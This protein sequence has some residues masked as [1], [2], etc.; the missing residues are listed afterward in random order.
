VVSA[1]TAAFE[2]YDHTTA[3]ATTEAFFWEFCDNYLELVKER[4]YG[5]GAAVHSART[6]LTTALDVQLRLF[7]PFLAFATEEIW[8]WS[9]AGS[10]HRAGWPTPDECATGADPAMLATVAAVLSQVRRA[11]TER[12]LSMRAE[13]ARVEVTGPAAALALVEQAA[14]DLSAAGRIVELALVA[15]D[16]DLTVVCTF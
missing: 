3:L 14:A 11:K 8:S 4:A 15:G 9:H 6:A 16:G 1:A 12:S 10:I 13:V 2:S 5:Q 7:A